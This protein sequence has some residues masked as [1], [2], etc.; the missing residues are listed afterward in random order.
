[1]EQEAAAD[2]LRFHIGCMKLPSCVCPFWQEVAAQKLTEI[3]R[4]VMHSQFCNFPTV[5]TLRG[6]PMCSRQLRP[7]YQILLHED[8]TGSQRK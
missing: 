6:D 4:C 3:S 1:M 2:A 8:S 7:Q 5:W